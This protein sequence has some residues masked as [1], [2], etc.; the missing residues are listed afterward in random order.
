MVKIVVFISLGD[1]TEP[2]EP[3]LDPP[4]FWWLFARAQILAHDIVCCHMGDWAE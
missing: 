3:P 1:S 4:Q 2:P